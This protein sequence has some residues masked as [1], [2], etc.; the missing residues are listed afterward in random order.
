MT[1]ETP[2]TSPYEPDLA[3]LRTWLEKMIAA[4]KFVEMVKAIVALISRMGD[5]NA[6]LVKQ[7]AHL[8][9]KRPRTESLDRLERQLVLPLVGILSP[10]APAKM[11]SEDK[12]KTKKSRKG[13][14]PVGRHPRLTSNGC[15]RTTSFQ[16]T[17]ESA[18][19]AAP[20]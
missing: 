7:L 8:R 20:R 11:R 1:R 9:R 4:M 3:Q 10:T 12:R 14:I 18:Q 2:I 19:S 13:G 16:L 15:L 17:S 5:I 6:E